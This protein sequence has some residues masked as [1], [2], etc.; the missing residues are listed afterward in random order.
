MTGSSKLTK[1]RQLDYLMINFALYLKSKL[2]GPNRKKRTSSLFG[3]EKILEKINEEE[4][5]RRLKRLNEG[6]QIGLDGIHPKILLE[7]ASAFR[8][9]LTIL[10]RK[11]T[12]ERKIPKA[13]KMAYISPIYK[14]DHRSKRA[15]CRPISLKLIVSKILESIVREGSCSISQMRI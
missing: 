4:I 1:K 12:Y 9:P 10:F 8:K 11:S 7:C 3:S 5:E 6:N 2:L 14:K 13:W 15:N